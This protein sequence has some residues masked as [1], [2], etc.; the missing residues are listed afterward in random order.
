MVVKLVGN[1]NGDQ[2][3]FNRTTGDKWETVVPPSTSGA[4]VVDLTAYDEAGNM[5]YVAKYILIIDLTALYVRLEP[6]PYYGKLVKT[7]YIA[8]LYNPLPEEQDECIKNRNGSR[9]NE[10]CKDTDSIP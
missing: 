2:V 4:Y 1:V 5:A 7:D 9:G 6:Y 8:V 10:T 3:I